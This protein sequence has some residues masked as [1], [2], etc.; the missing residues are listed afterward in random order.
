MALSVSNVSAQDSNVNRQE[1][2]DSIKTLQMDGIQVSATRAGSTTPVAYS[3]LSKGQLSKV[4]NGQDI[5]YLL[6]LTPSVVA[7]SDA[8]TGI[9]YTG[10]RIRGVD[11]TRIN[12]TSNGIPLND[13]ESH[14]LYWVNMPDF[15][16]SVED[17][18]VQ[19]GV[20]TSTNGSGAF[21]GSINLRTEPLGLKPSSE[22]SF[23]GGSFGTH[24]EMVKVNSGL[25]DGRWAFN[26]RLSNIHSDGYIERASADM[27]SWYAQGAYYGDRTVVKAL[28][29]GGREK[30]YHAWDGIDRWQMAENRRYNPCG[31]IE[32]LV[33]DSDGQPLLDKYGN[34]QYHVTGFYANQHDN[35]IQNHYQ[36]ILNHNINSRWRFNATLHYTTGDGYYEEYKNG[37]TLVEYG[38]VPFLAS[39]PSLPDYAGADGKV[40]KSNLVRRKQMQNGFG[41]GVFSLQ[42]TGDKLQAT[43]GGGWNRYAGEHFGRVIWIKDYIG[44]LDPSHEYYRNE[45]DKRDGNI[46]VRANYEAFRGFNIYA[47]MQYRRIHHRIDGRNDNFDWREGVE[48]MQELKVNNI[49]NFF[50]PK[51]GIFYNINR[52]HNV[53]A[54]FAVAHKEPTRNNFTDAKFGSVPK[55]E[56]L[57]DYEAGYAYNGKIFRAGVNL[58]YMDYK[59]Q[60][61]L[62][63]ETNDIGE[64][65]SDNVAKSYRAGVELTAGVKITEW[66]RW[67]RNATF[68]R[69]IIKDY[70]EYLDDYDR[71]WESLWTQT[72]NYVGETTIAYSPSV[73]AGSLISLEFGGF[74]ASLQSLYVGSQYVTNSRQD[75]IRENGEW[76]LEPLKLDAYFVNNLRLGYTFR[77]RGMKSIEIGVAVNNLFNEK[78]SSNGWG[79]SSL[80]HKEDGSTERYNG[81]YFFP[82]AGT[83]FLV[84]LTLRF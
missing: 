2:A 54:S 65:L 27:K 28:V 22:V 68:S 57:F 50:N 67:D 20:G 81:M 55:P 31:E 8:G 82:Q 14:S 18:Q 35:Y 17:I 25:I 37:R 6:T 10:V 47:D 5:P 76:V 13:A 64:P 79:Y 78:Y 44:D 84:N 66:L 26:A 40:E 80:I 53:Y 39:D 29:F 7:T 15:A 42:Y 23:S 46:F 48:D 36:L 59:D 75:G 61:V 71:N 72:S 12:V 83:N 32:S 74:T 56:R 4:N 77:L 9:G 45:T 62:T 19:R 70:T 21:G 43:L 16:S 51:A 3:D 38:L 1:K 34:R 58:Y 52:V 49:Y 69:N 73:I 33:R 63:G 24:R 41:G 11:A 60:L 30:T